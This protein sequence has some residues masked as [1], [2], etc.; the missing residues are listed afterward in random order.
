MRRSVFTALVLLI[1]LGVPAPARAQAT[2]PPAQTPAK[3]AAPAQPAS[4][5]SRPPRRP[6]PS[7]GP[8]CSR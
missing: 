7:S 8:A 3:P 5:L 6:T 2:T 4:R 1:A